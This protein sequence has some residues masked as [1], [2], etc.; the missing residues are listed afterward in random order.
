MG[1]W[2][3]EPVPADIAQ[4]AGYILDRSQCAGMCRHHLGF[5]GVGEQFPG[6]SN[7]IIKEMNIRNK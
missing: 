4:E 3:L 7:Q 5:S 2:G 1:A 6:I